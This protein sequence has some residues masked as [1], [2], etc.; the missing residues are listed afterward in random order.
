MFISLESGRLIV[1]SDHW[2]LS[3]AG[4]SCTISQAVARRCSSAVC[5]SRTAYCSRTTARAFSSPNSAARAFGCAFFISLLGQAPR[6][7]SSLITSLTCAR[8]LVL[9]R[10]IAVQSSVS[11]IWITLWYTKYEYGVLIEL[12]SKSITTVYLNELIDHCVQWLIVF[13]YWHC[14]LLRCLKIPPYIFSVHL[15]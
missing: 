2:W 6:F 8:T 12:V 14:L 7:Y 1:I 5:T 15:I 11:F 10:D 13:S 9:V 3:V 4:W